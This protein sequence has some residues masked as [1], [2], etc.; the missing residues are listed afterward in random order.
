MPPG[1]CRSR[2]RSAASTALDE[3]E[4]LAE[5]RVYIDNIRAKARDVI[6]AK[7]TIAAARAS[8]LMGRECAKCHEAM[9]A[10]VVFPKDPPPSSDP[11]LAMQMASHEWAAAR[12]WEGVIAP[13]D[14]RWL[15][16]ARTL[17]EAPLQVAAEDGSLG[18]AD[19]IARVRL[20][21]KRAL[22][23]RSQFDR[24]QLYGDL[25]ATCARCHHVIR[26]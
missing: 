7:D 4:A 11:R 26:D 13:S 23:P 24:A 2:S 15:Q 9:K 8:A 19:D 3:P 20:L 10:K 12:M 25:L 5:W 1:A 6:A 18:I 16:G 22:A 21:A 14:E 17:A